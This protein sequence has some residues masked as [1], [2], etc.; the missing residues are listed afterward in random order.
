MLFA[1]GGLETGTGLPPANPSG[2]PR[3]T[4]DVDAAPWRAI[5]APGRIVSG[6][7]KSARSLAPDLA[8]CA[9]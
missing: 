1:S 6:S 4:T 2:R 9:A 3:S 7:H 8:G 5:A